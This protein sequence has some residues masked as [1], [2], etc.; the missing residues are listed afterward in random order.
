MK[1]VLLFLYQ[2]A[3]LYSCEC[4]VGPDRASGP[5]ALNFSTCVCLSC[6]LCSGR[7]G[8]HGFSD[9]PRYKPAETTWTIIWSQHT[10]RITVQQRSGK[11]YSGRCALFLCRVSW[12]FFLSVAIIGLQSLPGFMLCPVFSF[13][14]VAP[15]NFQRFPPHASACHA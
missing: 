2:S 15:S 6:C 14:T 10:D 1:P 3:C 4:G 8:S 11:V 13:S 5:T 7:S 12:F 9:R